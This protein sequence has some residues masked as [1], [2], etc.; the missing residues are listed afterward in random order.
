MKPAYRPWSLPLPSRLVITMLEA[1]A[2]GL[3]GGTG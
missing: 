1:P 2:Y 3:S